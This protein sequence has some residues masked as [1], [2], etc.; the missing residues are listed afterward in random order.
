MLLST[1]SCQGVRQGFIFKLGIKG[2]GYY[3][4]ND[5][6]NIFDCLYR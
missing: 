2:L 4:D 6:L 3:E 5:S 1:L